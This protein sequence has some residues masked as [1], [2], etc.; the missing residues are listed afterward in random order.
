MSPTHVALLR[1][2]NV[3]GHG[4]LAMADLRE[5]VVSIGHA[6]VSTYLQSGNVAFAPGG[7]DAAA[8][9][10]ALAAG[11]AAALTERLG[12]AP[13]VVVATGRRL[14]EVV[15]DLTSG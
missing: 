5:V 12:A 11:I 6:D 1:A 14:R 7:P 10:G 9:P 4:R 2:V 15:A 3:G 13:A 8:D